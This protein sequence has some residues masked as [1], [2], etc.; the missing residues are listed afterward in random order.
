MPLKV[1]ALALFIFIPIP[2]VINAQ[3]TR[4]PAAKRVVY[5]CPMHP[6]VTST[7]RG[8]RCPKCKM[9]LRP[10]KPETSPTPTPSPTPASDTAPTFNSAKIPNTRIL[11]QDG[12]QLNFY[13][14]LIKGKTVAINFIFTTCTTVCPPLTA[15][16]RKVQ[17]IAAERGLDVRLVSVS[18]DPVVDTPERLQA[19]A[20]KFKVDQGWTFV[21]GDKG[22]MDTL[23]QALGA[24]VANKND[25][26]PMILIG[27]DSSNYW[28]RAYGLS[29]PSRLVELIAEATR[30]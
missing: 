20:E 13:N 3:S 29:S 15:T 7:K 2:S 26:T 23:L 11:D 10:V 19:F 21:T 12:K 6:E 17:Q 1:I 24:S 22:E 16:F 27:N 14:D 8:Q 9:A 4:K 18:V 25:H 28:T 30:R 5:A